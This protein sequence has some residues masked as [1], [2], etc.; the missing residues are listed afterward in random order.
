VGIIIKGG[1]HLEA[2]AAVKIVGCDKT[3]TLTHGE[4]QLLDLEPTSGWQKGGKAKGS[5]KFL[6]TLRDRKSLFKFLAVMEAESSHPMAAALVKAAKGQGVTLKSSDTA[7]DHKILKGEGVVG[8]IQGETFYVRPQREARA[9][10][11]QRRGS[12]MTYKTRLAYTIMRVA[13]SATSA[14]RKPQNEKR[15]RND[16]A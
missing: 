8:K 14:M 2:L 4:F 15:V 7:D 5:A 3:G 6:A 16:E 1:A 9:K 12:M 10:P 11:A 13:G